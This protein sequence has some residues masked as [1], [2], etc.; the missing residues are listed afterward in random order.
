MKKSSCIARRRA[1]SFI[2]P[3]QP[4]HSPYS[5]LSG[6]TLMSKQIDKTENHNFTN[7][8]KVV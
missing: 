1:E 2:T 7:N 5:I 3:Q 8:L 6:H 4:K